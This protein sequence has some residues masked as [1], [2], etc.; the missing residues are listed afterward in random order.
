MHALGILEGA[1]TSPLIALSE[2][3][4]AGAS[5]LFNQSM[6]RWRDGLHFLDYSLDGGGT[7]TEIE[8]NS[9]K[10]YLSTDPSTGGGYFNE[11][12]RVRLPNAHTSDNLRIRFRFVGNAYWWIID[13]VQIVET[14]C[15]NT[16]VNRDW[17]TTSPWAIVPA[18][19]VYPFPV[20]ADIENIG[21]C[22]QTNV[23]LNNLVTTTQGSVIYD[24]TIAYGN[25]AADVKD[26]NRLFPELVSVPSVAGS[27]EGVFTL[28]QDSVDFETGDNSRSYSFAVGGNQFALEEG[29][30]QSIVPGG[31]NWD[32]GVTRSWAYG[33]Y[34]HCVT[35]VV[36]DSILWGI[37][38]PDTMA[39]QSVSVILYQWTDNNGDDVANF[40]ERNYVGYLDYTITGDEPAGETFSVA[41]E[42]FN[43]K[44]EP[45][46]ME[47]GKGYIAMIEYNA[48]DATAPVL[49]LLASDA[50]NFRPLEFAFDSAYSEG[51]VDHKFWSGMLAIPMDGN[52][53]QVD[54]GANRF[55]D[56][57]N[58]YLDY[59]PV[60]RIVTPLEVSTKEELPLANAITAYP[61]PAS[62][63]VQVKLE[64]TKPY[65]DV[66]LRLIDNLGRVVFYK[67]MNQ[68]I[69]QHIETLNVSE[70]PSGNY[71]LQVE[72]PDGQRSIPVMVAK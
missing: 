15:T 1:V 13:D 67:A 2:F 63:L 4:V 49:E 71:L 35:S 54:Y 23:N 24:E 51:I 30:T 27:Y 20:M 64:F 11:E 5:V 44:G 29:A 6:Q 16:R 47:A 18:N 68:I 37:N 42:N 31:G 26:E 40:V 52:L 21:A 28:S 12:Y 48:P 14:E 39:G 43:N 8:I 41:L 58:P 7:W 53:G 3:N 9:E 32:P 69:S 55:G 36:A 22:T 65:G 38:N 46:V 66:K 19:Q 34:F 72:T 70:L 10:T 25:I 61:N 59:V 17:Y 50:R 60:V 57:S 62:D 56:P 45:I 33:N